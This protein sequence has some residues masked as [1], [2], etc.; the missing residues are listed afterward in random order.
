MKICVSVRTQK[1]KSNGITEHS[2]NTYERENNKFY[3]HKSKF[4]TLN[5]SEISKI[6]IGKG[7]TKRID[8]KL[9]R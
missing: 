7:T 9:G 8:D 1:Q 4:Y 2:L 3:L 6:L 5:V